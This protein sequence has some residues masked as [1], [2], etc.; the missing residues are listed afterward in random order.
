MPQKKPLNKDAAKYQAR[1]KANDERSVREMKKGGF[2]DWLVEPSPSE[3]RK[4]T[5]TPQRKPAAAPWASRAGE[6]EAL[7]GVY[8]APPEAMG[9]GGGGYAPDPNSP[10]PGLIK[11]RKQMS[12]EPQ[13][14]SQQELMML[15][16]QASKQP[17]LMELLMKL[18]SQGDESPEMEQQ[19]ME[20]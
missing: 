13:G 10:T 17:A 16:E 14:P 7:G 3:K 20:M 18:M 11:L 12:G 2:H 1:Q 8:N 9:G 19:E 5:E 15:L 6:D 4:P